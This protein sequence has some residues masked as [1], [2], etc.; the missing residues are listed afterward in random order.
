MMNSQIPLVVE[1]LKKA[2]DGRTAL[3]GVDLTVGP[4]ELVG[5]LGPNGAG[6]STLVRAVAG[7]IAPDGGSIRV[8]G[9]RAGS[10]PAKSTV[11]FVPQDLALYPL[12]TVREN[13]AA[14]GGFLG[15]RGAALRTAV[16]ET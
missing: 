14:F 1:E 7:R 11:G 16:T 12:L 13:L 9:H 2:F 4:G 8:H 6:K 3:A 10:D 15:L 5:L